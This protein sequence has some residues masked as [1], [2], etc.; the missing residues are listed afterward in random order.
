MKQTFKILLLMLSLVLVLG[1]SVL[2]AFAAEEPGFSAEQ[3]GDVI[4]YEDGTVYDEAT[5]QWTLP[6]KEGLSFETNLDRMLSS[7]QYMWKGM[8]CIFIVIGVIILSVY[9]L[10]GIFGKIESRKEK[11]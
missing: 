4:V 7:L 9:A 11:Q 6:E 2:P 5:K 10:N 1:F 8:L 3:I